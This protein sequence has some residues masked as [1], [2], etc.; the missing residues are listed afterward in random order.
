MVV[1]FT[2]NRVL[3]IVSEWACKRARDIPPN[4]FEMRWGKLKKPR[5]GNTVI[6][7]LIWQD[8]SFGM[9]KAGSFAVVNHQMAL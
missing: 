1:S 5:E 9:G 2:I 6:A 8:C 7:S 3:V 4:A